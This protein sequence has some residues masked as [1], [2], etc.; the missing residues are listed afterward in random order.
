MTIIAVDFGTTNT[1]I[2]YLPPDS[3]A[4]TTLKLGNLS[5]LFRLRNKEGE[6]KEV[7][8]IPSLV[9]ID[10]THQYQVGEVVRSR[11]LGLS[12]PHRFFKG[13]KRDRAAEFQ[14]PPR[15][16]DGIQ[17][18]P[19]QICQQFLE[20]IWTAIQQE[21]LQ[22]TQAVFTVPVGAFERYRD[23]FWQLAQELKIP[24]LQ[25]VDESTAAALG[26]AQNRPG[27]LVLVIDFGG[28]TL[29]LSLVRTA[30]GENEQELK[31]EVV[32][33]ADAYVGG[34]DIDAWIVEDYLASIGQQRED[35]D[36]TTWQN[37]L[38]IAERLK[39]RL[40]G[41]EEAKESWLNEET[42]ES[43][44][45]RLQRDRVEEILESRQ[46]LDELREALD[47]IISTALRKGIQ[48]GEIEQV[49]LTG[50]SSLIP[51]VQQLVVSFFGR[52]RVHFSNPFEA[53][54]H[55]ALRAA[56]LHSVDDYLRH[57]YAIRLWE[58]ALQQ[59]QYHPLFEK[60]MAYPCEGD[61]FTLQVAVD[62]Q[63]EIELDIGELADVSQVGEV[64]YD[65]QGRMTTGTVNRETRFSSLGEEAKVCVAHLDPPGK[66]GRDR[67]TVKFA[68]NE[69]RVLV[70]TVTD[71]LTQQVL[72]DDK[73]VIKLT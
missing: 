3:Q 36:E 68:V 63:R 6:T 4:P 11:R 69:R 30:F 12:Q 19:E 37:L 21:N 51:A 65:T 40:S 28:G 39:I 72:V 42:F 60:G 17:H 31:G 8:V 44:E 56:R 70:G 67:V 45:I 43:Y 14:P 7:P 62:G 33:K 48:K 15:E 46:L 27:S 9:F 23:W 1:V 54:S 59:Y 49:F 57:S 38:E 32:A 25:L 41:K 24:Q 13:F 58:P 55:G 50:G 64:S 10:E 52:K 34:G 47:D 2:S 18:T 20:I 26:Y 22:P 35:T 66:V 61:S 5:R 73:E 53:V 29:D 71:L 16:I